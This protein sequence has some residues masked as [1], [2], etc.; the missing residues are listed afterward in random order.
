M[1]TKE[2]AE[3]LVTLN[4][5]GNYRQAYEELYTDDTLS[6]ENWNERMEV[7][8]MAAITQKGEQ[9]EAGL[10]EMHEMRA[11]DPLVADNSFA[12]TYYIDATFKD[13]PDMPGGRQQMTELAVY[14]L[15]EEGKIF[16]EEFFG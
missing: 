5:A 3:R 9:W 11:S 8:G 2:I 1:T 12:V 7:R 15:N 13:T 14:R 4:R 16:H 10:A 6:I